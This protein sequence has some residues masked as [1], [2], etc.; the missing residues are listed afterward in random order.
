MIV[1]WKPCYD[2]RPI[3]WTQPE[4]DKL[5]IEHMGKTI[6]VDL[7]DTTI[8]EYELESPVTDYV[9]RAWREDG[10]LHL[11]MPSY[12]PLKEDVTINHGDEER[13]TWQ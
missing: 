10:V 2:H 7:S 6:A 5:V 8:V 4:P 12:G 3:S 11:R 9:H 13:I 1:E